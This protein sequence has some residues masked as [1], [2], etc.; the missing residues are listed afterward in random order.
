MAAF[1]A[2]HVAASAHLLAAEAGR[3][4]GVA[5]WQRCIL[6]DL[7][8]VQASER[9]LS[10]RHHPQILLD[11]VI[12]VIGELGQLPRAEERGRLDHERRIFFSV[13]LAGVQVEHP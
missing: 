7:V 5:E 2:A 8:H 11:I 13:A 4:S 3:I 9:H 10:R 1:D 12:Q 6:E